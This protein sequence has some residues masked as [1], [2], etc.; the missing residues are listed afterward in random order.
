M[1]CGESHI[2]RT[3]CLLE[4]LK[5]TWVWLENCFPKEIPVPILTQHITSGHILVQKL[6]LWRLN[7]PR[8]IKTA[9]FKP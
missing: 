3:W 5:R 6:P 8:G 4:I 7:T 9:I 2:K 1:P